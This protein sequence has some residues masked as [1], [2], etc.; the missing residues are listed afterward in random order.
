MRNWINI[1]SLI[2][3]LY[4]IEG[5][6]ISIVY[7]R[8]YTCRIC[9]P[10]YYY[11]KEVCLKFLPEHRNLKYWSSMPYGRSI[12]NCR[13]MNIWQ[14]RKKAKTKFFTVNRSNLYIFNIFV[15]WIAS[16]TVFFTNVFRFNIR[17]NC[18]FFYI[19]KIY[20]LKF[21]KKKK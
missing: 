19:Q 17:L 2:N 10:A 6:P 1:L 11:T 14:S 20:E 13:E 21:S 8:I 3:Q 16:P 15:K 18:S 5:K 4:N 7:H 12:F 9:H